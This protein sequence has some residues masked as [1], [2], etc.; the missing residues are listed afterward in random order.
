M[1]SITTAVL[2]SVLATSIASAHDGSCALLIASA[3]VQVLSC[4]GL[5]AV[6]AIQCQNAR[7]SDFR[8]QAVSNGRRYLLVLLLGLLPVA[9]AAIVIGAALG[10]VH[11]TI[12]RRQSLVALGQSSRVYFIVTCTIWGISVLL[13]S[14]Y[15]VISL[16]SHKGSEP[17]T[18]RLGID[19][20]PQDLIM[21]CPQS[22]V[23]T[24]PSNTFREPAKS[25]PSSLATTDGESSQRSSLSILK[26]PSTVKRNLLVLQRSARLS[27]KNS[28]ETPSSPSSQDEGF[29]AWQVSAV[30]SQIREAIFQSKPDMKISG[31]EPIPGSRSPSPATALDGPYLQTSPDVSPPTSPLLQPSISSPTSVPSSHP[32]HPE[33]AIYF[34]PAVG[35][36]TNNSLQGRNLSR[37]HSYSKPVTPRSRASSLARA[38]STGGEDHIHPLFRA[39]SPTPPPSPSIGTVVHAAPGAGQVISERMLERMRSGSTP[40]FSSPL[41]RSESVPNFR[42]TLSQSLASGMP[43]IPIKSER[44]SVSH[45]RKRSASFEFGTKG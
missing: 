22:T 25:A 44:R 38:S 34:P 31:L 6:F 12:T 41:T 28:L 9:A 18:S 16:W 8:S 1:W 15:L 7:R 10:S 13:E 5:I 27:R 17:S 19:N 39:G 14:T 11:S 2:L 35:T 45:Y 33:F 42:S 43:P 30:S 40:L 37:A 29:D 23:M 36:W 26:R 3:V 21:Q 20:D 4:F 32:E 24:T